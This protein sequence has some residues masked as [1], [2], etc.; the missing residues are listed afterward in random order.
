MSCE[1]RTTVDGEWALRQVIEDGKDLSRLRVVNR[2]MWLLGAQVTFGGIADVFTEAEQRLKGH[3]R[4]LMEDTVRYMTAEGRDVSILFGIPDY[5]NKF[6][7][8]PFMADHLCSVA[9]RDAEGAAGTAAGFTVRPAS[10]EDNFFIARLYNEK[11]RFRPTS[12]V[13]DEERFPGIR[14]G[15]WGDVKTLTFIVQ[16]EAGEKMGYFAADERRTDVKLV[17]ANATD[18]RAFGCI[19]YELAKMAIDRRAGQVEFHVPADCAFVRFARPYGCQTHI[20]YNRMGG[21]MMRILN[22][23]PLFEKLQPAMES[24]LAAGALRGQAV[25]LRVETDLGTTEL[26]LGARRAKKRVCRVR[27]RQDK[28]VQVM[29]GYRSAADVLSESDA[30][31]EGEAALVLD[32]LFSGQQPYVWRPDRF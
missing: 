30:E 20:T 22:Q 13:R 9:T 2:S 10:A 3:S 12:V 26:H 1:L 31:A 18:W 6:G 24:R 29:V 8:L 15:S 17:E 19:L 4:R 21:G 7:Y 27:L 32:A 14:K 23:E 5:Y 11:N 25:E 16:T 28:L